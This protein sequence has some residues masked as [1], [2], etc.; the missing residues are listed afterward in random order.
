VPRRREVDPRTLTAFHEAG[1]AVLGSLVDATPERVSILPDARTLGRSTQK[2]S[3]PPASMAQVFLAGFAAEHLLT[4]RRPRGF[5]VEVGLGILAWDDPQL[6]EKVEGLDATDGYGA[7]VALLRLFEPDGE[8]DLRREVEET[9]EAARESLSKA[10]PLV[11]AVAEELL[12]VGEIERER[13]R[14]V[15]GGSMLGPRLHG[16]MTAR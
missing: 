14:E 3:A 6:V 7:V 5:D 2:R 8:R 15:L 9:Y 12:A 13:L 10:W 1:H 16:G 11:A 4:G